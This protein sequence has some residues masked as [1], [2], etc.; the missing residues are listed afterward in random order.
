LLKCEKNSA[1]ELLTD[2][3]REANNVKKMIESEMF[4]KYGFKWDIWM[5]FHAVPSM[6]YVSIC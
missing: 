3:S 6:E 5:G 1:K 4:K 2:L